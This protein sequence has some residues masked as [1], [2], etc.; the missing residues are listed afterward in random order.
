MASMGNP[1]VTYAMNNKNFYRSQIP[2]DEIQALAICLDQ[3]PVKP[4]RTVTWRWMSASDGMTAF[5][6]IRQTYS[7]LKRCELE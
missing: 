1:A 7:N 4:P 2:A 5:F 3:A 6:L